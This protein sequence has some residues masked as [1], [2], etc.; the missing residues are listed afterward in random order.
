MTEVRWLQ[1]CCLKIPTG[2]VA[3]L[4]MASPPAEYFEIGQAV[5]LLLLSSLLLEL[6]FAEVRRNQKEMVRLAAR[7]L[8]P[9][10]LHW[11]QDHQREPH[12]VQR[13]AK[14]AAQDHQT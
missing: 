10:C 14:G 3:S 8:V 2:F 5:P 12:W 4:P 11:W 13:P 9:R 6:E 7:L 1:R